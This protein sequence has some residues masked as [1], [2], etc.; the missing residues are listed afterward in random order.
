MSTLIECQNSIKISDHPT[1]DWDIGKVRHHPNPSLCLH[2][3]TTSCKK[4]HE[5]TS[6]QKSYKPPPP[7]LSEMALDY[8]LLHKW[9]KFL[10]VS[11][12]EE[13]DWFPRKTHETHPGLLML[14]PQ[15]LHWGT[16]L[17]TTN[18]T[19]IHSITDISEYWKPSPQ[20][21]LTLSKNSFL[22]ARVNIL[23]VRFWFDS[24]DS[25]L[26]LAL[27]FYNSPALELLLVKLCSWLKKSPSKMADFIMLIF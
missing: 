18:A 3:I 23:K 21:S 15:D 19:F 7:K 8:I 10:K 5:N 20:V 9:L 27:T 1:T 16:L 6:A 26:K 14:S 25:T 4:K 12:H 11:Q 17:S 24:F 13:M 22:H 2:K